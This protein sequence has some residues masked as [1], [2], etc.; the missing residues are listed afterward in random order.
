MAEEEKQLVSPASS[1]NSGDSS[2]EAVR[3]F[4]RI[5]PLNSREK[6]ENQVEAWEYNETSMLEETTN[7]IRAYVYDHCFGTN[8]CNKEVYDIVGRRL[9]MKAMEGF[10]GT[11]FTYGQTGSGKTWTMRGSPDDPGMMKLCI[12]DVFEYVANHPKNEIIIKVSYMEVY[13]EQINDLLGSADSRDL[14]IVTDD[15]VRGAIIENLV[16]QVSKT[17]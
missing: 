1:A 4:V 6:R 13:N 8:S 11:V 3:V 16:E 2:A 17:L 10:N 12:S 7:G 5:R 14:K 15:P 9:V